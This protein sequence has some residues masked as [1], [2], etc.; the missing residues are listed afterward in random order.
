MITI[1]IIL[2]FY[3]IIFN[4]TN[5]LIIKQLNNSAIHDV[6]NLMVT[7]YLNRNIHP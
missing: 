7:L 6:N 4:T 3:I 1:V 5:Y 2:P